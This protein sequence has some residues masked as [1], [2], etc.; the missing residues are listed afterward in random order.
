MVLSTPDG[1]RMFQDARAILEAALA[2]HAAVNATDEDLRKL[3]DTL[4][5]NRDAIG[6]PRTFART[7]VRFHKEI[8]LAA[9]NGVV[10]AVFDGLAEWLSEQRDISILYPDS[11]RL[12]VEAHSRIFDAIASRDADAAESA[13]CDHLAQVV[14]QYWAIWNGRYK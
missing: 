6:D 3:A 9:R 1:V 11:A 8:A 7:D 13:M 2:R 4:Q 14:H 5:R 10:T 12:A